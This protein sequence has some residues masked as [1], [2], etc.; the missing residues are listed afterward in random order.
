MT[1]RSLPTPEELRQLLRYEPDTGKL[2]W[3]A[4]P[5]GMFS[6]GNTSVEANCR[7]W[8]TKWADGEAFTAASDNG[9]LRGAI[10]YRYFFAHRVSWA[11]H[12][13]RWPKGGIDH[14]NGC[15][16]DNRIENLREANQSENAI[17]S[18]VRVDNTSGHK[19]V[20]WKKDRQKWRARISFDGH[21]TYLGSFDSY[22]DAVR[23]YEVAADKHHGEFARKN[24]A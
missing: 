15:K 21:E 17:N 24:E 11:I 16:T 2:Y 6:P 19:G 14:I 8:N 23:A 18:V 20:S 22:N 1:K 7:A 13:G 9:Y 3:R 4:R 10:N 12:H 5:A